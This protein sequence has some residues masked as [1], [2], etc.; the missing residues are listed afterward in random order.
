MTKDT[1][2]GRIV[3]GVDGSPASIA[4]L[5]VAARI[6]TATG[7]RVDAVACWS[8]P[9]AL[10][11]SYALGTVE[12]EDGAAKLLNETVTKALGTPRPGNVSARLVQGHP[13]Q[14]LLEASEGADM[15]VVG[16]RG[17]GGFSGLLLGSVSQACV[18]H[19]RCPV[20]VVNGEAAA[21][22]EAQIDADG[23]L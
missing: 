22:G 23:S 18:A 15:L 1:G 7:V 16:R 13:R 11:V 17:R 5:Q 10:A 3:V 8:V 14:A 4:A 12:L 6:A 19:A 20:L 21:A 9:T 2:T